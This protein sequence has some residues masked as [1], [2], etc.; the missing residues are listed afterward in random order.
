MRREEL[1]KNDE[2]ANYS[3]LIRQISNH[4]RINVV[5]IQN[6]VEIGLT[7]CVSQTLL[8]LVCEN[9]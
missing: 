9:K 4:E 6:L 2:A 7:E 8:D 5:A 3:S 1:R